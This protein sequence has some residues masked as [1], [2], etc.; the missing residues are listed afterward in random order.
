MGPFIVNIEEV[1]G[2]I[3]GV[4]VTYL[5]EESEAIRRQNM[6]DAIVRR[7]RRCSGDPVNK[8]LH[9]AMTAKPWRSGCIYVTYLRCIQGIQGTNEG[10]LEERR[11]GT[12]RQQKIYAGH[13]GRLA[14]R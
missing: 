11:D 2:D 3:H 12:K 7:R 10:G 8:D 1:R 13:T 6:G 14:E 9:I 5:K 4:P